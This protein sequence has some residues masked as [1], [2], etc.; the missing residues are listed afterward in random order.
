MYRKLLYNNDCIL[1]ISTNTVIFN[2]EEDWK[3][4]LEWGNS[5]IEEI[6]KDILLKKNTLLWNG[7]LPQKEITETGY[8]STL[9]NKVG[10]IQKRTTVYDDTTTTEVFHSNSSV[11]IKIEWLSTNIIK[12][13]TYYL[14][15]NILTDMV[16]PHDGNYITETHYDPDGIKTKSITKDIN[17]NTKLVKV[18]NEHGNLLTLTNYKNGILDGVHQSFDKD[19]NLV[20]ECSY[21]T[22]NK[23]QLIKYKYIYHNSPNGVVLSESYNKRSDG[24]YDVVDYFHGT[25]LI[26]AKGIQKFKSV[27]LK[28]GTMLG[29]WTFYHSSGTKESEHTFLKGKI[30]TSTIY[31]EDNTLNH[32]I[33]HV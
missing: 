30:M 16:S 21:Y 29:T 33:S 4:Y 26:R 9:Y 3:L 18:F 2:F 6:K 17:L 28:N 11:R 32:S 27:E 7:G 12:A 23:I 5:N 19:G 20:K 13:S 25:E 24:N 15:G 1:N 31:Y 8:I 10:D 14:N 22:N